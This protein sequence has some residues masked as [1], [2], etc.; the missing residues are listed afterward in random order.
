MHLVLNTVPKTSQL[1]LLM[2]L[3][4]VLPPLP[5]NFMPGKNQY[6]S[7]IVGNQVCKILLK[8]GDKSSYVQWFTLCQ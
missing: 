5:V 4:R 8:I 6:T 1:R 2:R 3:N 7:A